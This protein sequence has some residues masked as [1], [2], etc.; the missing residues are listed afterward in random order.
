M[1]RITATEARRTLPEIIDRAAYGHERICLTKHGKEMACVI[2]MDDLR[3]WEMLE[4]Y[5]EMRGA[6]AA[7]EESVQS[8]AG[9]EEFEIEMGLLRE[10]FG[11]GGTKPRNETDR[12]VKK[13]PRSRT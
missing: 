8:S 13:Q 3:A 5:L 10:E 4:E 7:D 6:L 12:A 11:L 2:S 1:F 9:W